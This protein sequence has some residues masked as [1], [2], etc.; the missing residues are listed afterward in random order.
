MEQKLIKDLKPGDSVLTFFV[1]RKKEIKQKKSNG[2]LYLSFEFGDRSGRIRG[3]VWENVEKLYQEFHVSDVVKVKGKVISYR[4]EAHLSIGKMRKTITSDN[5]RPQQFLPESNTDNKEI[6]RELMDWIASIHNAH[7]KTLLEGIFNDPEIREKFMFAPAAKLW[8][9][10]YLGG[11]AE[12]TL[13]LINLCHQLHQLYPQLNRDVL[14]AAA[15]LHD[16]GKIYELETKG[17]INYSAEGRLIG[18]I[19]MACEIVNDKTK[20]I[21]DFPDTIKQQLLHCILSHH[22]KQEYG[23]PVVPMTLEALV[24]NYADELDSTIAAFMRIKKKDHEPGK[25]WS[26]YVNLLDRFLYI[27]DLSEHKSSD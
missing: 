18:H 24:L 6:D 20:N 26:N 11:L 27:E 3:S 12:H 23:S 19:S 17:F 22:G 14:L 10:N 16:L 8:H 9:H 25:Q 13:S 15:L 4:E 21:K 7:I 1:I 2:D 5:I